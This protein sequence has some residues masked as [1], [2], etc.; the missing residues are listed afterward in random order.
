MYGGGAYGAVVSGRWES[1]PGEKS[2]CLILNAFGTVLVWL[3]LVMCYVSRHAGFR[4]SSR[5]EQG[6][7]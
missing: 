7:A 4:F 6:E 1:A 5:G 2:D 3:S